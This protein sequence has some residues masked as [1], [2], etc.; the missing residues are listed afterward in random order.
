[1]FLF[2]F[3]MSCVLQPLVQ[4]YG[5]NGKREPI[6]RYIVEE[7]AKPAIFGSYSYDPVKQI[8]II[9]NGVSP[10]DSTTSIP[11]QLVNDS[12]IS[13]AV[14]E[15]EPEH[16]TH[17]GDTTASHHDTHTGSTA[18]HTGHESHPGNGHGPTS[19][20]FRNTP[21]THRWKPNTLAKNKTKIHRSNDV[22]NFIE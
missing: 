2:L 19:P 8:F 11:P 1:M 14:G 15:V 22:D 9:T 12:Y 10:G 17:H 5:V 18:A 16:T 4:Y 20:I 3:F 13:T 6:K 7:G 21:M